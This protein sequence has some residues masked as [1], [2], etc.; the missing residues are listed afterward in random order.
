MKLSMDYF[1]YYKSDEFISKV[2]DEMKEY[3]I[4]MAD[5]SNEYEWESLSAREFLRY[6]Y[7]GDR[8]GYE[9][10]YFRKRKILAY[11]VLGSVVS[12]S[13]QYLM[14]IIDG[15]YSIC[16]ESTWVVPA[17]INITKATRNDILA[18]PNAMVIDLFAS[19]TG[20]LISFTYYLLI[21]ELDKISP[22]IG[23]R[24]QYELNKRIIEPYISRNDF[25]WMGFDKESMTGRVLNNWNPWCNMNCLITLL[26]ADK[27]NKS[28]HMEGIE[29]C[30]RSIQIYMDGQKEDGGCDEGATYWGHATGN[31]YFIAKYLYQVSEGEINLFQDNKLKEMAL[32]IKIAHIS[33]PYFLSYADCNIRNTELPISIIS[34]YGQQYEDKSLIQMADELY[35]SPMKSMERQSWIS[36][37]KALLDMEYKSVDDI[38]SKEETKLSSY[39]D[40]WLKDTGIMC[41]SDKK[42]EGFF[43][44]L[45]TGHNGE[46]HNHNDVGNYII[47]YHGLPL[48]VDIGV[49]TYTKDTFSE[50]RYSIWTMQSAYHN[51]PLING[52]MQKE[53]QE[54]GSKEVDFTS[55]GDVNKFSLRMDNA[56]E[57]NAGLTMYRRNIEFR[58]AYDSILDSPKVY[59]FNE[60][61]FNK[62]NQ[63]NHD[64]QKASSI[65][66]TEEY[67]F[68]EE[69]NQIR[70]I[71]MTLKKPEQIMDGELVF[72][73]EKDAI[74]MVYEKD[75]FMYDV[76]EI[77]IEDMKLKANVGEKIYRVCLESK[78][79]DTLETIKY[80]FTEKA[81]CMN[82]NVTK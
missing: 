36:I 74:H 3:L 61:D 27:N 73:T 37:G 51:I 65:N 57:K 30:L 70:L 40:V 7:E 47:Y 56:Y 76:E 26:L 54:Y 8:K 79:V 46:S 19:E 11:L 25:W 29:K 16:E 59:K 77:V 15:I 20:S 35:Q 44:S 5:T 12:K 4:Q 18:N 69:N 10:I 43:L 72:Y 38:T 33:G 71:F 42:G 80:S 64:Y 81:Q 60:F 2:T 75:K 39:E 22:L 17:H 68:I 31:L 6:E 34:A 53:G 24:I 63:V 66:F 48:I 9:T 58:K 82:D 41:S 49:G 23:E 21:E 55:N 14:S 50:K 62:D 67:E 78:D 13:D 1:D 45:K 52:C 32:Y 28:I